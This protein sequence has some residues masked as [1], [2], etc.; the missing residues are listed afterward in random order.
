[1]SPAGEVKKKIRVC[2]ACTRARAGGGWSHAPEAET[3]YM[4]RDAEVS[5]PIAL[6]SEPRRCA[7]SPERVP[8]GELPILLLRA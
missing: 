8:P 6:T 2:I 5:P 4:R 3:A 7:S 1:M